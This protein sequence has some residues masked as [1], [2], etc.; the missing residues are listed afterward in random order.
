M[1]HLQNIQYKKNDSNWLEDVD[2]WGVQPT[3]ALVETIIV[4][5]SHG[6][7]LETRLGLLNALEDKIN[8]IHDTIKRL[9]DEMNHFSS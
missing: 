4:H 9:V 7:D 2:I 5:Y 1:T 6:E 8:E 3:M